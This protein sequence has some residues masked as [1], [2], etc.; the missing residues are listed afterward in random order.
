MKTIAITLLLSSHIA[1]AD[2]LSIPWQLHPVTTHNIARIDTSAAVFDDPNNNLDI[3]STTMMSASYRLDDRWAPML[4]LGVTANDA[5]GAALDGSSLANPLI[6]ATFTRGRIAGFA[7]I[8]LPIGT[9]GGNAPDPRAARTNQAS[10][11]ARP[12]D[13]VMFDVNY[14]TMIAGADVALAKH[15]FTAQAEASLQQSIRARGAASADG[16]DAAR[17]RAAIG[18]HIGTAVGSR[19]SLGV[20]LRYQRWLSHPTQL[21]AMT[22]ERAPIAAADLSSLT[23]TAGARVHVRIGKTSVRPGLSYTR[24]LGATLLGPSIVTNRTNAVT[25]DLPVLF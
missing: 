23:L 24:G 8:A 5:P 25:F 17:T 9:G 18:A 1:S 12:A 19:V 10:R 22:G 20:D 11:T 2:E 16:T 15:G 7:A 4:R 21:D 13:D 3:A 14:V 6:G